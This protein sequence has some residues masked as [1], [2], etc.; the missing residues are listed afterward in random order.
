MKILFV[1]ANN[2]LTGQ[3]FSLVER[4][5][6]LSEH[7][8]EISLLLPEPGAFADLVEQH[9]IEVLF[10]K[11][12]RLAKKNP[13]PFLKT[14]GELSK[15][16]K[17]HKFD[18]IHCSGMYPHQYS[19]LAAKKNRIPCV[20]HVNGTAYN[21]YDFKI[22]FIQY[23]D[24][25]FTVSEAARAMLLNWKKIKPERIGT[26][27][28]GIKLSQQD[29]TATG[30]DQVRHAFG[31]DSNTVIISQVAEVIPRK[32][33]ALFIR[34]AS[35]I[36]KRYDHA[37]FMIIG[38][39]HNDAHENELRNLINELGLQQHVIFTGF[40][41]NVHKFI[42]ASDIIVLA[43]KSEGL[44][45]VLVEG[46]KLKRPVVGFDIDG[47]S[48][49]ITHDQTGLIAEVDNFEALADQVIRLIKEPQLRERCVTNAYESATKAFDIDRSVTSIVTKYQQLI[50]KSPAK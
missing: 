19:M 4:M 10:L 45:R 25:I 43:S 36:L 15:L 5:R 40:Q 22:N 31:I 41:S 29:T 32:Q 50:T 39:H 27:Y 13:F 14:V 46:Q 48:E 2:N 47:I 34:M 38:K 6:A 35:V 18:L 37:K 21:E 24:Y 12:S 26:V 44:A 33:Y 8:L 42:H 23:A 3:E 7:G 30:R 49:V 1:H 9:D 17:H 20:I 28:N 16:V 11:Q